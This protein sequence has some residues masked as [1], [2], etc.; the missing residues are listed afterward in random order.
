MTYSVAGAVSPSG[1]VV[2]QRIHL[3]EEVENQGN[4]SPLLDDDL[5]Q[6]YHLL[7]DKGDIQAQVGQG[8]RTTDQM[9]EF[10]RSTA[11]LY[12]VSPGASLFS[13]KVKGTSP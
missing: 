1:G 13:E 8:I 7:A 6:Y 12:F 2:I 11:F 9:L 5:L 3:Q 4:N 10:L